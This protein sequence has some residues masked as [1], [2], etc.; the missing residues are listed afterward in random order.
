MRL[1]IARADDEHGGL[2]TCMAKNQEGSD[3]YSVLLDVLSEYWHIR[4]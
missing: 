1:I 2:Y 4:N 3:S